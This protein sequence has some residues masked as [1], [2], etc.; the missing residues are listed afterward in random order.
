[1]QKACSYS[2]K[3]LTVVKHN[4]SNEKHKRETKPTLPG[5][6]GIVVRHRWRKGGIAR[7]KSGTEW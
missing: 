6:S 3:G 2:P 1:M 7:F 5:G 4:L